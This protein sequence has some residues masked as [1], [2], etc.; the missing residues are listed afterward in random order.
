[1]ATVQNINYDRSRQLDKTNISRLAECNWIKKAENVVLTGATDSG[2]SFLACALGHQACANEYKVKY[3]NTLKLLTELKMAQAD[4]TVSKLIKKIKKT[5]V[6][7][8]DD[9]GI[10]PLDV[11]ARLFLLEVLED[12]YGRSSSIFISQIPINHWHK[13]I[14][15]K[16]IADAICDRVLHNSHKI[17]IFGDSLRK[18]REKS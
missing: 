7:I 14:G 11:D 6:I 16:T 2:K 18:K 5:D 4:H 15:D 10:K 12:R 1:M 13:M 9:F 17:K 8:L 3:Y